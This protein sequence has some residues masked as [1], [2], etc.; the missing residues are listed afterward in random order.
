[1]N[2][3]A[4]LHARLGSG[5]LWLVSIGLSLHKVFPIFGFFDC[6]ERARVVQTAVLAG[7]TYVGREAA[8]VNP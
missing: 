1:M 4:S 2:I 8:S 5:T 3:E 6:L 7:I